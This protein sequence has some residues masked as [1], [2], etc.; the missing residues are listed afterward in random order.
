MSR[1]YSIQKSA[2]VGSATHVQLGVYQAA[3]SPTTRPKVFEFLISAVATP[4]DQA[5]QYLLCLTSTAAP[6]GGA[7]PTAGQTDP[8][9]VAPTLTTYAAAT[10]G[11]T[12]STVLYMVSVNMRATFRWVAVPGYEFMCAATQYAGIGI[13]V[14]SQSSAYNPDLNFCWQE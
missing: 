8:A 2:A 6:T 14:A 3:A 13:F 4:A 12:K 5:S 9:E 7:N 10:G 1:G 11:D